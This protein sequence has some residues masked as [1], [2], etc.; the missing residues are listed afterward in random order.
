MRVEH[1]SLRDFK[2]Y[3][4]ADIDLTGLSLASVVGA[5]GAGKS[6][7]LEAIVFALTG[8]RQLRSLDAFVRKGAEECRVALT[9]SIG[10]ERYRLTRT[11][12]TRSSGK[13]TLEL[14]REENGLWVAEG[15][16]VKE[17]EARVAA[18][19]AVDEEILLLTSVITQEDAGAFFR[20]QPAQRLEGLGRILQLDQTYGPLAEHMKARAAEHKAAL[21]VCRQKA[22]DLEAKSAT[23]AT[24]N[25]DLSEARGHEYTSRVAVGEAQHAVEEAVAAAQAAA[26]AVAGGDALT[27]RYRELTGRRQELEVR[28]T[29]LLHEER[30]LLART[31]ERER[32][33]AEL[34]EKGVIEAELAELERKRESDRAVNEQRGL[35]DADLRA[36]KAAR[37]ET[38]Q[39]GKPKAVELERL[40][41]QVEDLNNRV[42]DIRGAE[43]PV[44]DRC[45][46]PI[47]N[48]ALDRTIDQLER[49]LEAAAGRRNETSEEVKALRARFAEQDQAVKDLEA[50]IAALPAPTFRDTAWLDASTKLM[51]LESIPA[52]LAEIDALTERLTACRGEIAAAGELLEDPQFLAEIAQAETAMEAAAEMAGRAKAAAERRQQTDAALETKRRALSD[53]EKAV[54][55][56]EGQIAGLADVPAQLDAVRAEAKEHERDLADY[57]LLKKAFSKW[58]VPALIVQNVLLALER[59]VNELLGLYDGGLALRFESEK[60][61]RDGARDSL[62][63]LVYDGQDWRPYDTFSGGERYRVASAM[64]L[65]LSKLLA[66]RAGSRVET[67]LV[68]EPEG[69]DAAGRAHLARILERMSQGVGLVLLLTHYEDLKDAMPQQI[70]VSRGEDGLSRVEVAA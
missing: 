15:T 44:C 69:L 4:E 70:V 26:Q 57:E 66:H 16:Q 1:L 35:L 30:G 37:A 13:S 18:I 54:A 31:E 46:Q 64:R 14:C 42:C 19:L 8:G 67:L 58:G 55:R 50:S 53:A 43:V 9:F 39:A 45:G 5:N 21:E 17:T 63:I 38:S 51:A 32:L 62:E 47:A 25:D 41:R 34:A 6:S 23:L 48:E 68:D 29:T 52:R 59:E 10:G 11:R 3:H 7:I 27:A 65:G 24:L 28:H 49:E 40:A 36:A 20:L 60:E 56:L 22:E 33:E 2:S 12:S 61:T